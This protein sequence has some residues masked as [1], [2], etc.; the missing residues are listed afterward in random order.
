MQWEDLESILSTL[1]MSEKEKQTIKSVRFNQKI[2]KEK[3]KLS[4]KQRQ[5]ISAKNFIPIKVIG[6]GAFGEVRLCKDLEG[7]YVA[8]KKLKIDDMISK[9]QIKHILAEREILLKAS[10][11]W[12]VNLKACFKDTKFLY[13]G[14]V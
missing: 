8:I 13:L 4:R 11:Q 5:K 3:F 7:N 14:K 2:L 1:D 10:N 12:V 9:N 6:K